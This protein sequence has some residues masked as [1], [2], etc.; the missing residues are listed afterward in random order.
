M[1][2]DH[3]EIIVI[4]SGPAGEAAAM[5]AKKKGR[6]VPELLAVSM[7]LYSAGLAAKSS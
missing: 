7:H 5:N 3:F 4:G 2:K 1:Q 6:S